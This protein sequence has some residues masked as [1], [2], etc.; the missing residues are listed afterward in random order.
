MRLR[1]VLVADDEPQICEVL[2]A[3]LSESGYAVLTAPNGQKALDIVREQHVDLLI[4]DVN[5]P[6][7]GGPE[8]I[9][10]ATRLC[11]HLRAILMSGYADPNRRPP[12]NRV[13]LRKPFR[14]STLLEALEG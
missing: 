9:S 8:L 11:P 5:M 13:L 10:L 14:R 12:P 1:T 6:G 4:A 3:V 7:M 2:D